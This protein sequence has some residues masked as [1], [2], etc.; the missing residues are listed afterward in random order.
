[1]PFKSKRKLRAYLRRWRQAHPDYSRDYMRGYNPAPKRREININ[2]GLTGSTPPI[3]PSAHGKDP[4]LRAPA[5]PHN[6]V[7]QAPGESM[8]VVSSCGG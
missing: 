1:M 6:C 8:G 2:I 3:I 5:Q 4:I 7:N